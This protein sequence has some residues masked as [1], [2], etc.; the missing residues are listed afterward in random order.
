MVDTLTA[1][2][3]STVTLPRSTVLEGAF[4][5]TAIPSQ[6][7]DT[8]RGLVFVIS[9][10]PLGLQLYT[11]NAIDIRSG[12]IVGAAPLPPAGGGN[13]AW[14]VV[15]PRTRRVFALTVPFPGVAVSVFDELTLRLLR[16]TTVSAPPPINVGWGI[17]NPLA[18]DVCSARVFASHVADNS[19]G[20]LDATSGRLLRTTALYPHGNQLGRSLQAGALRADETLGRVYVTDTLNGVM[21]TLDAASGRALG[22]TRIGP[23][24][25][26]P[27]VDERARRLLVPYRRG[28][29]ALDAGNGRLLRRIATVQAPM[30]VAATASDGRVFL[31]S[32]LDGSVGVVGARPGAPIR[33]LRTA[34]SHV[35]GLALD[36]HSGHLFVLDPGSGNASGAFMGQGVVRVLDVTSGATL[37]TIPVGSAANAIVIDQRR[38]RALVFNGGGALPVPDPWGWL[39]TALRQ[40]LPFIP[41]PSSGARIAPGSVTIIDTSRL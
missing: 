24:P 29:A 6:Q 35:D 3:V 19:V 39:P 30:Y 17:G 38:Q 18:V 41:A 37:R 8:G 33:T 2:V 20:V 28:L 36:D 11:L 26:P 13:D 12:R 23:R 21:H 14:V 40:R 25:F 4:G 34:S 10:P 5:F 9:H 1:R 15:D 22:S 7:E 16:T 32:G 27:I 31:S